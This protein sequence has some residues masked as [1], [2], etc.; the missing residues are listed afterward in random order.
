MLFK[1]MNDDQSVVSPLVKSWPVRLLFMSFMVVSNWAILAILTSVISDRMITASEKI[2]VEDSANQEKEAKDQ[3]MMRLMTLFQE[4]D[5]DGSGDLDED[6]F[7]ALLR[8][9][10]LCYE[11]TDAS[12]LHVND[13][14]DLFMCLSYYDPKT[15]KRTIHYQEFVAKLQLEG[16]KAVGSSMIRLEKEIGNLEGKLDKRVDEILA[17]LKGHTANDS[18]CLEALRC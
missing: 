12:K 13:L 15:M 16:A 11:L 17:A 8:D 7:A 6:E 4:I 10:G 9:K 3:A 2:Q 18:G 14:Q 1:L 5:T